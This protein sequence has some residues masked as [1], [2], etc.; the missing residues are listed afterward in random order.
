MSLWAY[1]IEKT[2]SWGWESIIIRL[3]FAMII[4]TL[5]G[6]DR[7]LKS[8][9]AGTKTHV[10]VCVG[11]ALAMMTSEY[12]FHTFPAARGDINRIG[13]QVVS[14]VG[15]LG[16]GTIVVTGKNQVRGLT[17]AAGLWACAC[18]G[19]AIGIGFFE[20][21][22]VATIIILFTLR[23]LD[24]VDQKLR[25][26]GKSCDIYVE[27]ENNRSI[28][29]FIQE[30]R[31]KKVKYSNFNLAKSVIKG[32]GP[33]ATLTIMHANS[34]DKHAFMEMLREREYIRY[35]EEL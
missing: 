30:M 8:R 10:L 12:V 16:V 21:T 22:F 6:I 13:A 33:T 19:I 27:F 28:Q 20:G 15:F 3:V 7:E 1:M 34:G 14:G 29:L 5:I 4:G 9:G 2:H 35:V 32:E 26:L 31:E 23:V 17:T 11:A 25:H 18:S 24:M